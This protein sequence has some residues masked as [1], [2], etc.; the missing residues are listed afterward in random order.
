MGVGYCRRPFSLAS[1]LEPIAN[2]TMMGA[3]SSAGGRADPAVLANCSRSVATAWSWGW[4]IGNKKDLLLQVNNFLAGD[5]GFEPPIMGPEPIALPLG[6]SPIPQ[7][8]YD[9]L[10]WLST[11]KDLMLK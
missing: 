11:P 9:C 4:C 2:T 7:V 1:Y 10:A 3:G 8:L 6:Q 5:E